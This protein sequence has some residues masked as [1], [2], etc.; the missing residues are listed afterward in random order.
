MKGSHKALLTKRGQAD[1]NKLRSV[2]PFTMYATK[3]NC[4]HSWTVRHKKEITVHFGQSFGV[5]CVGRIRAGK[6]T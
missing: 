6:Q 1:Q 2:V 3:K 5:F 4:H